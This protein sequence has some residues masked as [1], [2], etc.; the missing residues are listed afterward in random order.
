MSSVEAEPSIVEK[1]TSYGSI[2]KSTSMLG[3][4][5]AINYILGLFRTKVVAVLLGP[6]GVGLIGMYQSIINTAAT[7]SA[8]GLRSSGVREIARALGVGDHERA[9]QVTLAIRRLSIL[10]GIL[11]SLI[12][13]LMAPWLSRVVFGDYTH[14]WAL[15]GLSIILVFRGINQAQ[16]TTLQG[17]RRIKEL[18]TLAV[19]GGVVSTVVA[20]F[21]YGFWGAKAIISV[22]VLVSAIT[23]SISVYYTRKFYT[24]PEDDSWGQSL[25]LWRSLLALGLAVTWG[26]VLAVLV[27]LVVRTLIV[28]DLGLT[29]NGIYM[30]AWAISGLLVQ[31]I[32]KAMSADFVPRLSQVSQNTTEV[33]RLV[34]EQTEIGILLALPGVMAT[35]IL[36][37]L[38]IRILYSVDFAPAAELMPWFLLGVMCQIVNWPMGMIV[39]AQ[40][41][42]KVFALMNSISVPLHL[43]WVITLFHYHGL[44]GCA[45]GFALHNILYAVGMLSFLRVRYTFMW[46]LAVKRMLLVVVTLF[47]IRA[48]LRL[49]VIDPELY[50]VGAGLVACLSGLYSVRGLVRRMS[51]NLRVH[52]LLSRL[53][54]S[55]RK[56]L[57]SE[58]PSL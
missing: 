45:I 11:A 55:I 40:G 39:L 26:G 33:N 22:L 23:V 32:T 6:S 43:A 27:P 1:K 24:R 21:F 14:V 47:F 35:T 9:A 13:V 37:P 10:L 57:G 51:G 20:V 5:Q 42:S 36:A 30:A 17:N 25:S 46:S 52:R 28:R 19:L 2:L 56:L 50:W 41:H 49:C 53:P 12:F 29:A 31:F 16:N 38:V 3:G 4:S 18:A 58:E 34:N 7:A 48:L 8:L 54:I 44:L 15:A